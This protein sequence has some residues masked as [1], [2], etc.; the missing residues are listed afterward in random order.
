[1]KKVQVK[2]IALAM[3]VWFGS[4]SVVFSNFNQCV[5]HCYRGATQIIDCPQECA[6]HTGTVKKAY[7]TRE[8]AICMANCL[9]YAYTG[10]Y[11]CPAGYWHITTR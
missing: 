3:M 2:F 10:V 11:Q 5:Y 7:A 9:G 4:V 8:L 6:G 1:M